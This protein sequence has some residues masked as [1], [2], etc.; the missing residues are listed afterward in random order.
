MCQKSNHVLDDRKEKVMGT[1]RKFRIIHLLQ[2]VQQLENLMR[3]KVSKMN[4]E[5]LKEQDGIRGRKPECLTTR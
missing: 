5:G 4:S 3:S 2:K 1:I